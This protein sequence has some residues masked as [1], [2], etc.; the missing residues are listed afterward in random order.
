MSFR[1]QP[2]Q[3]P[4]PEGSRPI[5]VP[6]AV[7]KV[8]YETSTQKGLVFSTGT[9]VASSVKACPPCSAA[10]EPIVLEE[11]KEVKQ[12]LPIRKR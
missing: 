1:C 8:E 12:R 6:T 4:Q 5:V 7:R 3:Q 9:E 11:V 10:I 2:C